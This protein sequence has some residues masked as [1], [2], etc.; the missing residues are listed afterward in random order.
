MLTHAH[1]ES[2]LPAR[3]VVIGAGF[4][5]NSIA[6]AVQKRGVPV[7][8]LKRGA[9]DLLADNAAVSLAKMLHADDSVVFVSAQAPARSSAQLI[10]N[11]RMA[12]AVVKAVAAQ[13]VAHLVYISSDAVYADDANPV[14]ERSP[15]QP[16]SLHGMMHAARELMLRAEAKVP[17]A[18]LRPS[19]LYGAADPHNGYGPNRF[20]RLAAKGEAIT[21]FGDGEEM[22]DH[23]LID[24]AAEIAALALAHR[25]TGVLNI[26][27]G[28][29]TSFRKIAE[30]VVARAGRGEI[31]GTPRQ[32][33][34]THRHFDITETLKAFPTF[35]YTPLSKGLELAEKGA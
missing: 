13:P 29:S 10:L 9:L 12:E 14:T 23:V 22:R 1:A 24:D 34:I 33:P 32:N 35:H 3:V 7:L 28:V 20:R 16:S 15:V 21:L 30:A 5:G 17:L 25:S 8:A 6:T 2:I 27:T 31:K 4:V 11:L 26:A 19:L 18:I